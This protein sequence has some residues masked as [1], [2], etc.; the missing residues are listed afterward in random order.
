[1]GVVGDGGKNVNGRRRN[2]I[3]DAFG[4]LLTVMRTP[5]TLTPVAGR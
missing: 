4:L 3:V 2:A 1:M 5:A